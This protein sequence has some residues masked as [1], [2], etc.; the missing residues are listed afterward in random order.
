M[1][2]DKHDRTLERP[3]MHRYTE[4][5]E[6]P[7]TLN[8]SQMWNW[9]THLFLTEARQNLTKETEAGVLTKW[10]AKELDALEKSLKDHEKWLDEW[11]EKQ[12]SVKFN[13]DPVINTTEMKARAKTLENHLQRLAKRK[14]PK[15]LPKKTSTTTVPTSSEESEVPSPDT[16]NADPPKHQAP[17]PPEHERDPAEL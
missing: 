4:I 6:F 3:I 11:V 8:M 5:A 13:E 14:T 17:P 15:P 12:K 7:H 1:C 2:F 9:R 10:T 16:D